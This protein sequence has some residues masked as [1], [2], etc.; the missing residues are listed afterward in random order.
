MAYQNVDLVGLLTGT[1]TQPIQPLTRNQRLAQEAGGG[2]RAVG[3]L[4]AKLTGR[5]VPDNPMEQLEKL[6]PNMNPENPDD[7]SQLAKLQMS[8]GNQV[9]AARTIA[10]RNAILQAQELS[11]EKQELEDQ[12]MADR[13]SLST[14]VQ[15]KYPELPQLAMLVQSGVVTAKNL[16][17]FLP[18]AT[19]DVNAQFGGSD[20][21]VDE[22][23]NYFYGT[24]VKDPRTK[25]T[26]TS[27]SPVDAS[28]PTEPVGNVTPVGS[29]GE[30]SAEKQ[31]RMIETS[32]AKEKSKEFVKNKAQ[33]VG[34]LPALLDNKKNIEEAQ[35][36]LET[37]PTGGPINIAAYGIEDFFGLTSGN[38]ADFERVLAMETFKSLKPIFGGVISDPERKALLDIAAT[39][40]RGNKANSAI[41]KRLIKDMNQRISQAK[42]YS[43]SEDFDEYNAFVQELLKEDKEPESENKRVT[44]SNL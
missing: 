26:S 2:G 43:D 19:G 24:Q 1:P 12:G 39:V 32:G 41:I 7:L 29:S 31:A 30:T 23:G 42:L 9:G 6:L 11:L 25:T 28:G 34:G 22:E 37:L 27:L 17:D 18:D 44:W 36:I 16:K 21:W 10:Q 15:E 35:K 20:K 14:Y 38:R 4:F 3:K 40:G 13:I 8:S 5:E 33:A